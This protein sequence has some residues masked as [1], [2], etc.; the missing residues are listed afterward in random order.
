[1]NSFSIVK[2]RLGQY[3]DYQSAWI[4]ALLL[5]STVFI[6]NYSHGPIAFIAAGKQAIYTFF[7]AGFIS[8]LA[9][10]LALKG[11]N[12]FISIGFSTLISGS[13]A[14]GLTYTM[15]SLKGTPEPLYSTIPTLF[16]AIPGFVFL[17]V[18]ARGLKPRKL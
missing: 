2:N 4:A 3:I 13:I 11:E 15:H 12:P 8:R 10:S 9:S 18:R 7:I 6:I 16:F 5:G 17:G 14:I 1:M